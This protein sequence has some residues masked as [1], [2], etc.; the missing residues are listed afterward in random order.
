MSMIGTFLL[1]SDIEL[2]RVLAEPV[3]VHDLIDAAYHQRRADLVD[4]DKAWHALHFLLTG[5]A[6]EGAPPLNFIAAGG[7]EVGDEDVGY[8]PARAF[9]S[10][11]LKEISAALDQIDRAELARRFDARQMNELEIYPSWGRGWAEVDPTSEESFGYFSGA[12]EALRELARR[13]ASQGFG[14]LVW[15]S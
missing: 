14:L 3:R 12:Y 8:G 10:S 5:T 15:I 2:R 1:V 11:E 7:R 9:A 13:G 4:V 6:W